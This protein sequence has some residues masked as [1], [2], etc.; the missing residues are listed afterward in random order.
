MR[1][2]HHSHGLKNQHL[3]YLSLFRDQGGSEVQILSPRPYFQQLRRFS[4]LRVDSRATR[5]LPGLALLALVLVSLET[6]HGQTAAQQT[7]NLSTTISIP[8]TQSWAHS[9]CFLL[10]SY[11]A[12]TAADAWATQRDQTMRWHIERNPRFHTLPL[13]G[14]PTLPGRLLLWLV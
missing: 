2:K 1:L 7:L 9:N 13:A 14:L 8:P 5:L 12:L 4:F 11:L 6:A 3:G 10:P